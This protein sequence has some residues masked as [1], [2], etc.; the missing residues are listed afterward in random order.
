VVAFVPQNETQRGIFND[1]ISYFQQKERAGL[2]FL[3]NGV[4]FLLPPCQVSQR[5]F[6]SDKPHMIGIF[7][8]SQASQAQQAR[9][10]NGQTQNNTNMIK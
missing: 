3:R 6:Q 5:Y 4:M 1:Y 8:D 2:A 7:G 10:S 9:F